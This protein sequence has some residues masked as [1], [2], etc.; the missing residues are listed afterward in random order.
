MS[1]KI[2]IIIP[3]YNGKE[4][5]SV[6][7]NTCMKQTY[8]NI[9]IIVIDDGST[10]G[11]QKED[12]ADNIIFIQKKNEGPGIARNIG[13]KV[14]KGDYIFFL[15]VDDTL[16]NTAICNLFSYINNNDFIIGKT[17]R[18][19][20]DA[21]GMKYKEE[22]WKE[23]I[24]T[25]AITKETYIVDVLSTNKLY[26]KSFLLKNRLV[27]ERGAYEDILF[28]TKVFNCTKNFTV[29][30]KIIYNWNVRDRGESRSSV[31][32]INTSHE[33]IAMMYKCIEYTTDETLKKA[34]ID[35][36]IKHDLKRYV[37]KS[38]SYSY[39]DLVQLYK[40]YFDFVE[41]YKLYIDSNDFKVNKK[42]I[43][44]IDSKYT[45]INEFLNISN[46]KN[47]INIKDS[48]HTIKAI[49]LKIFL[50]LEKLGIS[51]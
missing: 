32:N 29:L 39:G 43:H 51:L 6:A 1:E 8:K 4:Y 13:M 34:L 25:K 20:I 21:N 41:K 37:N 30:N 19:F 35:N 18:V 42:L 44:N 5:I 28:I 2:S 15:D 9:E 27:F 50:K 23:S 38:F 40:I 11:L 49:I 3:V 22:I 7:I 17:R 48:R 36:V 33:R 14:A 47:K 31:L 24:Y 45:T 16:E 46:E 10:D 26:R 12:L